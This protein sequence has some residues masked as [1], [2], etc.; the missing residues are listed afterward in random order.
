M[1]M[2]ITIWW[3]QVVLFEQ[4][5]LLR[6]KNALLFMLLHL[7]KT[8]GAALIRVVWWLI[9]FFFLPWTAF[10]VPVLGIWYVL[11]LSVFIL[12]RDLDR[13]FKIEEQILEKFPD[14]IDEE[15]E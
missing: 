13:D 2:L 6:L 4:K 1:T 14:S 10:V 8:L 15:D 12:Y 5:T 3:V 9:L 11:F 7:G